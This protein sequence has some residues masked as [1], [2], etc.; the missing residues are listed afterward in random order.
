MVSLPSLRRQLQHLTNEMSRYYARGSLFATNFIGDNQDHFGMEWQ[1]TAQ[2]SSGLAYLRDMFSSTTRLFG[3]HAK[4]LDHRLKTQDGHSLMD[5]AATLKR[6]KNGELSYKE[7]PLGGCTKVGPCKDLGL[8]FIDV[9]CLS[10]CEN[11]VVKLP[12][13]DRVIAGQQALVSQLDPTTIAWR[14]ESTDLNALVAARDRFLG[15]K[16][17]GPSHE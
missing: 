3:G 17:E 6:F 5:R 7:T 8:R 10:G 12:K 14:M 13:L 4:W 9:E 11:L 16:P 15:Q 1:E 2:L